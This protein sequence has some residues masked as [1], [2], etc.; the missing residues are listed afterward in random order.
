MIYVLIIGCFLGQIGYILF[1]ERKKYTVALISKTFAS[2]CFCIIGFINYSI[3]TNYS[4][5]LII[6]GLIFDSI[7]DVFLGL[8]NLF[9]KDLM[10]VSGSI[11]FMVGHI[12]YILYFINSFSDYFLYVV[13]GSIIGL[14][15][16]TIINIICKLKPVYKIIGIV[17]CL[18]IYIICLL[19]V[20]LYL[21]NGLYRNLLA[22]IGVLLFACSD[23]ILIVYN[24]Y[25][26]KHWMHP[27][28]SGLY[29][30]AQIII[31]LSIGL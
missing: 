25:Q 22:M 19:G 3:N 14:I 23:T 24:F 29:Y 1:S 6:Y 21:E 4:N 17:Y 7:G 20:G 12:F 8:R 5:K 10:F 9:A 26:K 31:A 15:V 11:S 28:Y 27:V 13:I 2:I 16:Y 30:L 18:M